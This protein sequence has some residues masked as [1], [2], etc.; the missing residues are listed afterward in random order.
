MILRETL[1]RFGDAGGDEAIS[2]TLAGSG[3]SADSGGVRLS[4]SISS[5]FAR[6]GTVLLQPQTITH[7]RSQTF[8]LGLDLLAASPQLELGCRFVH[9]LDFVMSSCVCFHLRFPP[10]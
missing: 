3:P 1:F 7:T 9:K 6:T 10:I 4:R 5:T 2:L 8:F